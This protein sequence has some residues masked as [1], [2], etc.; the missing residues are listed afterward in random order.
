MA[1]GSIDYR[2]QAYRGHALFFNPDY[3]KMGAFTDAKGRTG[4]RHEAEREGVRPLENGDVEFCL[5]AP[6]AGSVQVAGWTGSAMTARRR[7]LAQDEGG[8]WSARVS[9]IPEGFHYHDWFI[10][11]VAALN[12]LA[13]VGYGAHRAANFFEMPGPG[14]SF[15]EMRDVEHGS[16]RMEIFRSSRTGRA[17]SAWVYAP[18][19][20]DR[21]PDRSYPV[22]YLM[23]GGGEDETGW[24]WQ[25]KAN[26]IVDNLVAEKGCSEVL[27]VMACLY[28]ELEGGGDEFLPGDFDS[29][30]IGDIMPRVESA[31]RVD[32]SNRAMAGLSMGSHQTL[33]TTLRHLGSFPKIG[34]F[35][36]TL[37]LRWYDAYDYPARFDDAAA[38]NEAVKLFFL[39]AGEGEDK[40]LAGLRENTR[41]LDRKGIRYA[42]HQCPG[43]HE[44]TVWRR[45][46]REFIKLAFPAEAR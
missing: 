45:H 41:M 46:L 5:Y 14:S 32:R 39:A 37:D 44:W 43:F 19:G 31:Y 30:L 21:E 10:D 16:L 20:Y 6:G 22:L 28:D 2:N 15:Y 12:P 11:G 8:Y 40:V 38:F 26:Y 42:F 29:L 9:G 24:I 25:G 34:I 1:T 3:L 4:P 7:D 35:S 36:G 33:Q 23:H 17:R 18:P 27:I 13:P